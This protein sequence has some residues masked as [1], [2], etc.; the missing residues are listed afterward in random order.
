MTLH[1]STGATAVSGAHPPALERGADR[2]A[3]TVFG[4]SLPAG[5]GEYDFGPGV[6]VVSADPSA[7][8]RSVRLQVSIATDAPVGAHDLFVGGANR[9]G[10]LTVHDGVDRLEVTPRTGMARVGGA[11]FPKGYQTFD[12][13]G[14]DDGA[15]GES[16][17][18]DDLRLG[19]VP[20]T[21]AMEEYSAT[22]DDDDVRFVGSMGPDGV[23]T[24]N[25]DGPNPN[26]S[27]NRNNV[28]DVWVVATYDRGGEQL[29][30][31]AHLLV[32][33]PLYLRFD[34][35]QTTAPVRLVP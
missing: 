28:G 29:R 1:R 17:T 24:P 23:F 22:Y 15:D 7:D 35:W 26:R 25:D 16:G 2:V 27:G 18:D 9:V 19:R 5:V 3:V 32:T 4:E 21:W 6:T 8:G 30:A 14:W 13:I 10:A 34:P 33:V 11:N 20:V 12:A 31:R